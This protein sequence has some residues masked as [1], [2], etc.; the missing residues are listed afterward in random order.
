MKRY[1]FSLNKK[2]KKKLIRGTIQGIILAYAIYAI[3]AAF[4]FPKQYDIL[5][6]AGI[7]TEKGFIAISYFGVDITG[8]ETLISSKKLEEHLGALAE[9]G[10]VTITQKD[11]KDYY[12]NNK[13]LP[14]KSLFLMFEDGRRDTAVFAQKILE[15]YNYKASILSYANNLDIK[16]NKFLNS[17]D[18]NALQKNS[19]WE[20]GT[21]G[22]RLSY[23]N[24]FDRHDNFIGEL[25]TNEY[26]VVSSYLDRN[27]NHYLM[28]FIRDEYGIPMENYEE[29]KD[30]I[31]YDYRMIEDTYTKAIGYVPGMYV[32]MHSNTGSFGTNNRVSAI[33]EENIYSLFDINF[34]R[35]GY[36][37]NQ[38]TSSIYDL[39]RIQPQAY[40]STNHLL[41]RIWEDTKQDVAF[42]SGDMNKKVHWNTLLGE[43]EFIEDTIILTSL[44]GDKG[45]MFL[46]DGQGYEDIGIAIELEG[47]KIG[48]Q[49][50][51]MRADEELKEFIAVEIIDNVLYV[52]ENNNKGRKELFSL[53]LDIH[54]GIA[55]Q[56]MNENKIEAE[57]KY[58]EA[59]L[60]Y[61]ENKFQE[62]E[63]N[64][65]LE[66]KLEE[67]SKII[68]EGEEV[69]VPR[70][71]ILE[72]GGRL[73][74]ISLKD[75]NL[76]LRIDSK[77]VFK[78]IKASVLDPGYVGLEASF[79][80]YGYSQR[81]L[82]DSIYDGVFKEIVIRD[83]S[84][85]DKN[86]ED[87]LYSNRLKGMEKLKYNMKVVWQKMINWFIKHL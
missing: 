16:D 60:K 84:Q 13:K 76:S 37:R 48:S 61:A 29:M 22:Y 82:S 68:A 33:N 2:D 53:D 57:I 62:D 45:L 50:V 44:P 85:Q 75:D 21:N 10:Y 31:S 36:S 9:S 6:E 72:K 28:D 40:W 3:L 8:D 19:F 86:A 4:I 25:N 7:Q 67:Q 59:R 15:K 66:G 20:I 49:I 54:D 17:T 42:E 65:L 83:I 63:L 79:K 78:N 26:Q 51:Y 27:Y 38:L 12:L 11:I 1:T 56:S 23:I 39:T 14:E 43:S 46:K 70:T 41:M 80:D 77:E 87:I 47:N 5:P 73:L 18:L 35:E 34:N 81:N 32:L 30:R 74:E 69:Y 24:A 52:Y 71:D 55:H 58:L 64:R